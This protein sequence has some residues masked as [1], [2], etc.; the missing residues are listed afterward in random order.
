VF[1]ADFSALT[2]LAVAQSTHFSRLCNGV[3][4]TASVIQGLAKIRK[5]GK[6][7]MYQGIETMN[8]TSFESRQNQQKAAGEAIAS[9]VSLRLNR[10]NLKH[11]FGGATGHHCAHDHGDRVIPNVGHNLPQEDPA[12]F[13][14]AV[15]ELASKKR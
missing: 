2:R 13:A 3:S 9:I 8:T 7:P 5:K 12:A 14:A 4:D 15:W 11:T 6:T 1:S 10:P